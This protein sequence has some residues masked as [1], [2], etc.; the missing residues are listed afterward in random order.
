MKQP[1][2]IQAND[3]NDSSSGKGR[4]FYNQLPNPNQDGMEDRSQGSQGGND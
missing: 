3:L 1:A 2:Q 4:I